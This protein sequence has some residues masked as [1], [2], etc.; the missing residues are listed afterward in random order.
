MNPGTTPALAG[1]ARQP[2]CHSRA[3]LGR[4]RLQA[5]TAWH[6]QLHVVASCL[7]EEGDPGPLVEVQAGRQ[8]RTIT[9]SMCRPAGLSLLTPA[10]CT[11]NTGAGPARCGSTRPAIAA[12]GLPGGAAR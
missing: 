7:P 6:R 1:S 11:G 3:G 8:A 12:P 2:A 10:L 9:L 4:V 5:E